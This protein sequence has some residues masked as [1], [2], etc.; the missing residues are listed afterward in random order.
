MSCIKSNVKINIEIS[1]KVEGKTRAKIFQ[2]N[3]ISLPLQIYPVAALTYF[4]V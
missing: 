4:E 2:G 3:A 1:K